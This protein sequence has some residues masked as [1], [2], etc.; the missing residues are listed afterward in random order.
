MLAAPSTPAI[1]SRPGRLGGE[2]CFTGT[3]VPIRSLFDHLEEGYT[4]D[5]FLSNFP[6][7]PRPLAL[8]VLHLAADHLTVAHPHP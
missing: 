8:S 1:S 2:P 5:E 4:L 7:V 6:S 3:R